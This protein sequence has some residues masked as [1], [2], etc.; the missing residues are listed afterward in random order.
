[1]S[2][3]QWLVLLMLFLTYLLLG[4]SIFHHIESELEVEKVREARINRIEINALLHEH[5][6]PNLGHGQHEIFEKL[7]I[8]CGK[9]VFNYTENEVDLYKWDFY[10]SFYFAYTV[11]STIGY[12]NLAPTNMLGRVLMIFYGLIGIPMNGILL[13]QLG[14]FFGNVFVRAHKKYK[15]YKEGHSD[16]P[17]RLNTLETRRVGLAAQI[18]MY[19]APGFVMFIFFPAFLFS[20]YEGW[21]YD[22]AVYYAFVT[23]TTI[24]FGD[25]VAGQDNTKGNGIL[26]IL[27][28]IFLIVWIVFG[29]GYLVMIMSFIARGMRSKRITR[30]EHKLAMNLKHTQSKI[31]NEFNK[32][33]N[34]SVN[35]LRRVFNEMYIMKLKPV[36]QDECNYEIPSDCKFARSSSFPDL[37][38]LIYGGL[39]IAPP[40]QPRR[41]ANSEIAPVIQ[42]ENV[43]RV[44]SENDLQR[45][46]KTATFASHA[47]VQSAELIAHLVNALGYIPPSSDGFHTPDDEENCAN[48]KGVEGF[49]DKE[50]LAGEKSWA[51]SGWRIGPEKVSISPRRAR[52]AS[53]V[54][55]QKDDAGFG[56][57]PNNEWT[58][59]GPSASRNIQEMMKARRKSGAY[60]T[61]KNARARLNSVPLPSVPKTIRPRWLNPFSSKKETTEPSKRDSSPEEDLETHL[62]ENYLSHTANTRP[63]V[64]DFDRRRSVAPHYFTHCGGNL[65]NTPEGN[66]LEETSLAD[67]LRALTALHSRVGAVPDDLVNRPQRKM[68]TAS[69]TP[70]KLPSLLGLFSPP[71]ETNHQN[72]HSTQSTV[73]AGQMAAR[74]Y[75]LRPEA[76]SGASTPGYRRKGSLI[77]GPG[78]RRFSLRSVFAP[79]GPP[80]ANP[81]PYAT[82]TLPLHE[83]ERG[84]PPPYSADPFEFECPKEPLVSAEIGPAQDSIIH[85][86]RAP[87][88]PRRFSLRPAQIGVPPAPASPK[89][90]LMGRP[91]PKWKG[92][93]L[94]RQI[95]ELN[96]QRRA[97]AFSL[98]DVNSIRTE[99]SANQTS[100]LALPNATSNSSNLSVSRPPLMTESTDKLNTF[101]AVN[102]ATISSLGAFPPPRTL[103]NDFK[104]NSRSGSTNQL[105]VAHNFKDKLG[106]KVPRSSDLMRSAF[107]TGLNKP[108][109]EPPKKALEVDS[110]D[111]AD[112]RL[113]HQQQQTMFEELQRGSS[114]E[115][116][117]VNVAQKTPQLSTNTFKSDLLQVKKESEPHP[118]ETYGEML[119]DVKETVHDVMSVK[120]SPTDANNFS[121][122]ESVV[123]EKPVSKHNQPSTKDDILLPYFTSKR[124]SLTEVKV[125]SSTEVG[126]PHQ[127]GLSSEIPKFGGVPEELKDNSTGRTSS[128]ISEKSTGSNEGEKS[129]GRK[130]SAMS[131]QSI[132]LC[133]ISGS[134]KSSTSARSDKPRVSIDPYKTPLEFQIEKPA[135][136]PFEQY[137]ATVECKLDRPRER[138]TAKSATETKVDTARYQRNSSNLTSTDEPKP[139]NISGNNVD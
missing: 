110:N 52:A 12:G 63:I 117:T 66:L 72:S 126:K 93:M 133:S 53:E 64:G 60:T 71:T 132:E 68:G 114:S 24:G 130:I 40:T 32:D 129:T 83:K 3:R 30:L 19:L 94:Q 55:L 97:R 4:A 115:G 56:Q 89:P 121:A 21:Q 8:Y 84:N 59:S 34:S 10:N 44:R 108:D 6:I 58:W 20:Y 9:S 101:G 103:A 65:P 77:P 74:R 29:L 123:V 116:L 137:K 2:K 102:N 111:L 88:A 98:G 105:S 5:Y 96:L 109:L 38:E 127:S 100:P 107:R 57:Q 17:K 118:I 122:L 39:E 95:S 18:F 80:L 16:S 27:Y 26:W 90:S 35:Y 22:E 1:M 78:P 87:H 41:R 51:G 120:S 31:W 23:L 13:A 69:L 46:D 104:Q 42:Y 106:L 47:V 112:A 81:S 119:T 7:S 11:V 134:R 33:V 113:M 62:K 76:N 36:Y 73:T 135:T 67:F 131:Q 49:S 85:P 75:S 91:V 86:V 124:N 82:D 138:K 54:R 15:S 61:I 136:N 79:G 50:I 14:E 43:N 99:R 139:E 25:Y 37:R 128:M 48:A 28:K 70:P 92:G 125:E 45:I